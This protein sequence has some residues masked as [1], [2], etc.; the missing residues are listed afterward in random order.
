[1]LRVR[2]ARFR[3]PAAPIGDQL[4]RDLGSTGELPLQQSVFLEEGGHH[5]QRAQTG[6]L[7]EG[8]GSLPERGRSM[9]PGPKPVL[10]VGNGQLVEDPAERAGLA[11]WGGNL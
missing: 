7:F 2:T 6:C 3:K 9:L 11:G 4:N 8:S 1:M 10:A 5:D